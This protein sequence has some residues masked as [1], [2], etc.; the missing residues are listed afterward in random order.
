MNVTL[1]N[2]TNQLMIVTLNTG[3]SVHLAPGI[4]SGPLAYAEI[5]GNRKIE[6]LVHRGHLD[7]KP[8]SA[9]SPPENAPSFTARAN[10]RAAPQAA[11]VTGAPKEHPE[12]HD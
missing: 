6:N 5:N 9:G 4:T 7:M 8:A 12:D 2:R 1:T 3:R 11:A 10:E